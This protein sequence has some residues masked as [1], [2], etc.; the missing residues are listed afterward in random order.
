MRY[1]ASVQAKAH[2]L[3]LTGYVRNL[4]NGDV[5]IETEGSRDSISTL[6]DWCYIGS[7]LSKV[8]EVI[9]EEA[10]MK[11]FQTFEVIK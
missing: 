10:D 5:F 2:K 11:N 3:N 1:R 8:T 6:I 7:P 9:S 4:N